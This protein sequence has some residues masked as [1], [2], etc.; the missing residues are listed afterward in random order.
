MLPSYKRKNP[1]IKYEVWI[2]FDKD[3][4]PSHDFD[5]A[6]AM[7]KAQNFETAHSNEAFEL[8]YL[9]HFE[10]YHTGISRSQYGK[11][12]SNYLGKKYRKK[13]PEIYEL[14]QNLENSSESQAIL[15]AEKLIGLHSNTPESASNPITYVHKLIQELNKFIE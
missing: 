8:W 6:I 1:N 7:A 15:N 9:L 12:L 14:L 3:S 2:V 11:L 4:F 5:N 10:F 13:D